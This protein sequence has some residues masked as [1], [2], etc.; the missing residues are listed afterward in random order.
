MQ[1]ELEEIARRLR[2]KNEDPWSEVGVDFRLILAGQLQ[3]AHTNQIRNELFSTWKWCHRVSFLSCVRSSASE[4][5]DM[6][7]KRPRAGCAGRVSDEVAQL[8]ER[9]PSRPR[10]RA[11]DSALH[12]LRPMTPQG[13]PILGR[14]KL[15]NL[16]HNTRLG[17]MG[18]TM[19]HGAARITAD[20]ISGKKAAISLEGLT[21]S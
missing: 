19:S 4:S 9:K 5:V 2:E 8:P 10:K 18:W 21:I 1:A 13:T 11:K 6:K 7:P 15:A 12:G 14:G 20:L 17:H 16:W 3:L